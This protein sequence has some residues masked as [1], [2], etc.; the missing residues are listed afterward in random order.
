MVAKANEKLKLKA[1]K[2]A[3]KEHDKEAKVFEK[4]FDELYAADPTQW[5]LA[6]EEA[7]ADEEDAAPSVGGTLKSVTSGSK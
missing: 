2:D 1:A 3:R 6:E 5:D 4:K 7:A